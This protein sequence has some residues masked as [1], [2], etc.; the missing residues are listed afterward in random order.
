MKKTILIFILP[1]CFTLSL[2]AQE[3]ELEKI[4]VTPYRYAQEKDRIVSSFTVINEEDIRNSNAKNTLEVLESVGGLIVRDWTGTGTKASIDMRGFGEQGQMNVLVLVD[5]R[6]V[7]EP[8]LSGVDWTQLPLEQIERI[9]VIH[10]GQG[11]VL[12]GDNAVSGVINIITKKGKGIPK[13]EAVFSAGSYDMHKKYISAGGTR[14]S[15]SYLLSASHD[16]THGYRKNS[17]YKAKD[18]ALKL[19]QE[20]GTDFSW[21]FD[22]GFHGGDYGLPGALREQDL[23]TRSRRDT[24]FP[25]DSASDKNYYFVLGIE[26]SIIEWGHLVL[27]GIFRRK[28]VDTNF[29]DANA[30]WNPLFWSKVDTLGFTPRF[31]LEKSMK[32]LLSKTILGVDYYYYDYLS[33]NYDLN[34]ILQNATDINK[35]SRGYYL[36]EELTFYRKLSLLGGY[37]YESSCYELDFHD[38]AGWY[39][40]VDTEVKPKEKAFNSGLAY[41]YKDD[42]SLYFNLNRSFRF[43]AT[44]EYYSWGTLNLDLK[45]QL[46]KNYEVGIRHRF[47]PEFELSISLF[48]MK[49]RNELYYNPQGGPFGLGANENYDRTR[50]EGLQVGFDLKPWKNVSLSGN[51][52]YLKAFF[53]GGT[54]DDKIIPMVPRHKANLVLRFAVLDSLALN[55]AGNYVGQRYFINDQSNSVSPLNGFFTL[56]TNLSY[57]YKNLNLIFGINNLFDKEYSEYA[58]YGGF[59]AQKAYY[60]SPGRNFFLKCNFEF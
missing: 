42:S 29:I 3:V 36:Q 46:S 28:E 20:I 31:T 37:R 34:R 6:R 21:H 15:F 40:D 17:Y 18:F 19:A 59:P 16:S 10:G 32:D 23:L 12:Y 44:D 58:V 53:D 48:L 30:G 1:I 35:I 49:I 2:F 39:P 50:R 43:P 57:K 51:Y 45:P 27:E 9:E 41:K 13:L 25:R 11:G 52:S 33:D 8:D 56:D 4:V 55:F 60:P 54:Y 47:Y 26:K 7:N 5:G 38:V 14:G 24:R 22:Y